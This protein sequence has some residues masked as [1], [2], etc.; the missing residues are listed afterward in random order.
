[1]L[2]P[3]NVARLGSNLFRWTRCCYFPDAT[4]L[5]RSKRNPE[6]DCAGREDLTRACAVVGTSGACNV[7]YSSRTSVLWNGTESFYQDEPTSWRKP[8][9]D[10]DIAVC[11]QRRIKPASHLRPR[12][13]GADSST[14][15]HVLI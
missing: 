12:K 3:R 13:S 9:F 11:Y 5:A 7:T 4:S 2:Q 1:M 15:L 14:L 6:S 8:I 10:G